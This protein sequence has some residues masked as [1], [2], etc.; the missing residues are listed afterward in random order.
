MISLVVGTLGSGKTYWSVRKIEA[1]LRDGKCVATNVKLTDDFAERIAAHRPRCRFSS[2]ARKRYADKIRRHYFYSDDLD[3]LF[4]VRLSGSAEGRGVMVLDEAH[5]WMNARLWNDNRRVE[6]VRFFTQARKL[7]WHVYL[8][9]QNEKNIDSQ[10]RDLFEY[11]IRLRNLRRLQFAGFPIVPFNLFMAIRTWNGAGNAIVGR[12]WYR[13]TWQ[14]ALYDTHE[15]HHGLDETDAPPGVV[16]P[17][18][19]VAATAAAPDA[20]APP[21]LVA[22]TPAWPKVPAVD[23]AGPQTASTALT[24]S[25]PENLGSPSSVPSAPG[26]RATAAQAAATAA[27]RSSAL[28]PPDGVESSP[29]SGAGLVTPVSVSNLRLSE[30]PA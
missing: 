12:D 7:G 22:P 28:P 30:P 6:I 4:R 13:L 24:A 1:A 16:L 23:H 14:K 21:P 2:A 8:I 20:P 25:D 27:D 17:R 19:E 26:G 15:I 11:H 9:T 29:R 10:V 5:G 18:P 3:E